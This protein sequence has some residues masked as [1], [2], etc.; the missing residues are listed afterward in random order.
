NAGSLTAPW[1]WS[2]EPAG[3]WKLDGGKL[4]IEADTNANLWAANDAHFLYQE[5]TGDFDMETQFDAEW[6]TSSMVLGLVAQSVTDDNWVTLKLWG[7]GGDAWAEYA[8]ADK[9][10]TEP[11]YVGIYA[12]VADPTGTLTTSFDFVR[13]ALGPAD[14]AVEPRNKLAT[15]WGRIKQVQ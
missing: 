4:T 3:N 12:G 14:T 13:D 10:L 2:K 8:T 1:K 7:R 6:D 9:A 15:V 11:L 5:S